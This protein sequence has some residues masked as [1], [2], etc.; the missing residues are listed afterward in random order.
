[1]RTKRDKQR[2]YRQHTYPGMVNINT[3]VPPVLML[4]NMLPFM[5]THIL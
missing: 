2:P 4:M 5:L 3:S 1:M